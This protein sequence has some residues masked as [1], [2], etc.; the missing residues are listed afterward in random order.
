MKRR[1]AAALLVLLAVVV[2]ACAEVLPIGPAPVVAETSD[3]LFLLVARSPSDRYA[4]GQAMEVTAEILYQGPRNRETIFHAASPV[5]WRVEQLDGPAV[6]GGAMAE[7]CVATDLLPGSVKSYPFEKGGVVE[8]RPPFD[9]AWFQDPALRL[10]AGRWRF[11]ATMQVW[12]GD[13]G[14]E[15]HRLETSIDVTVGP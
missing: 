11:T 2:A 7:P 14:G 13:C 8:D 1:R 15:E 3:E 10:P 4:A 5:G 9:M 12:L 6:M